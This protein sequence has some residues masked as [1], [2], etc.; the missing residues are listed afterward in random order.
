MAVFEEFA[1]PFYDLGFI[2]QLLILLQKLLILIHVH[3]GE[4]VPLRDHHLL[5]CHGWI[6]K[7]SCL[8]DYLALGT[9]QTSLVLI[10]LLS[11]EKTIVQLERRFL[12]QGICCFHGRSP[13]DR[14]H[15][16]LLHSRADSLHL[17]KLLRGLPLICDELVKKVPV[18]PSHCFHHEFEFVLH[19][20]Y[21]FANCL[22]THILD[23]SLV[24]HVQLS[25]G[26]LVQLGEQVT[27]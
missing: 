9:L 1:G 11:R 16:I 8:P 22:R 14:Q 15:L 20:L 25:H 21:S 18:L 6:F 3:Q 12:H 7:A 10:G 23:Q 27:S 26:L 17:L 13:Q 2:F 24:A 5:G 19:E 4:P